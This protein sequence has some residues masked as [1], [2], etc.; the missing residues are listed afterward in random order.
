MTNVAKKRV[1]YTSEEKNVLISIVDKYKSIIENKTTNAVANNE[2]DKAWVLLCEDFNARG[3]KIYRDADSLRKQWSNMKQE[4][5]KKA[6][7]ERQE[8]YR[9]GGGPSTEG[10]GINETLVLSIINKKT[11]EGLCN[12]YDGDYVPGKYL[13]LVFN[14]N[15]YFSLQMVN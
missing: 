2:K 5:K 3:V 8:L 1:N 15:C 11:T 9:T 12:K 7:K 10:V 13:T 14:E 4:S 6:A